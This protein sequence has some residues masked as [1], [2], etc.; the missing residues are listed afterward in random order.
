MIKYIFIFIFY[1]NPQKVCGINRVFHPDSSIRYPRII[2]MKL[3]RIL[4]YPLS[5]L[6]NIRNTARI[7]KYFDISKLWLERMAAKYKTTA[8]IPAQREPRK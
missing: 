8:L 5:E 6:G 4:D 3:G 1:F 7:Y 2:R